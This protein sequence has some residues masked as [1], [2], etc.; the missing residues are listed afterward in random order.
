MKTS[1]ITVAFNQPE[2]IEYQ[3]NLLKKFFKNDFEFFVYNNSIDE[4]ISN[5]IKNKCD[6]NKIK[7]F[8]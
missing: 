8:I 3:Y 7:Y 2:F 5:D 6:K 1:V 4:K